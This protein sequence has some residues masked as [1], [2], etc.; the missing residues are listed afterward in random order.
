MTN[1]PSD[2]AIPH[3]RVD[4]ILNDAER[5]NLRR[6][7]KGSVQVTKDVLNPKTQVRRLVERQKKV[8]SKAAA[9]ATVQ[10][11]RNAPL[12]TAVGLAGIIFAARRPI[13]KWYGRF[14]KRHSNTPDG[15]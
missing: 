15:D 4:V 5:R 2:K 12:L 10:V 13:T 1:K 9:N 14:T 6:K 11:K 8:A 7:L 3:E